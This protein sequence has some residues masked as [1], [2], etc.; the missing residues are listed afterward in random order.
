MYDTTAALYYYSN[1]NTKRVPAHAAFNI[2]CTTAINTTAVVTVAVQV[3]IAP[4]NGL[5]YSCLWTEERGQR[6]IA[7]IY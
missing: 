4:M 7:S 6:A 5:R 1:I 3:L 2:L